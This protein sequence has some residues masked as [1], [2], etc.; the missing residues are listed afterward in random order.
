MNTLMVM[1][2]PLNLHPPKN[3]QD[4]ETLCL[5]LW[6][7]IWKIPHEIEFNSDNSQGQEG[8]DIYGP[9]EGG[10]AYNG[11]QCKNKKLNLINGAPNRISIGDIQSEIDKAK[12]FVPA[13]NKLII[14]T[15]LPKDRAIEEFVRL[16]S[17]EN[18]N[19]GLF[20][21]QIC[22]WEFF[23]RK[24]PEFESVYNWYVKNEDFH[25]VKQLRVTFDDGEVESI[26]HPKFQKTIDKYLIPPPQGTFKINPLTGSYADMFIDEEM[27][28]PSRDIAFHSLL[29][30]SRKIDW[31]QNCWLQLLI[32][33]IGQAVVEDFKIELS[34]EGE[35]E[36]VEP[37][38]RNSMF[39]PNFSNDVKGYSDSKRDLYIKPRT[40]I[41]V[42]GDSFVSGSF[43]IKPKIA[44]ET[45]VKIDWKLLSRDFTDSGVLQVKIVPRYYVVTNR[46]KVADLA[47]VKET[48]S[49]SLIKRRG[50][51]NIGGTMFHDNE[52]DYPVE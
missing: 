41:L 7:E 44:V 26:Y 23:E 5:R 46:H 35:F 18:T 43:R 29:N 39:N 13:L 1:I 40:N 6:G 25:R 30:A 12:G 17:L 14:A 8:V 4:F 49:Y 42:Q 19:N 10:T 22:F 9:I 11:I 3:W 33:N 28:L 27:L 34:F 47:D 2:A 52:S 31:S 32:S 24:I 36:E 45:T 21:I 37:E 48:I 15:S 51:Y 16:Q 20:T 38:W 50:M